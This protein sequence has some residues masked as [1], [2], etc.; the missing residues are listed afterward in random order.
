MR[1]L[2]PACLAALAL[3]CSTA[4]PT[5]AP[6]PRPDL[7]A[8]LATLGEQARGAGDLAG[9]EERFER[10]LAADPGSGA[11]RLGLGRIALARG[12]LER[13][14]R[15]FT[16]AAAAFADS[17]EA[18]ALDAKL[19]LA[20]VARG[21][22]REAE[23][24]ERLERILGADPLRA[25]AHAALA[26]LTGPA[27]SGPADLAEALRRTRAHPYDLAAALAA[28]RALAAVGRSGEA[29][30]RLES[31]LWL[32]DLDP[33]AARSAWAL[34]RELEPS[35]REW[36]LVPVHSWADESI[37]AAPAWRFRLRLAWLHATRGLGALLRVRFVPAGFRSFESRETSVSLNA[38]HDAFTRQVRRMPREGI[39]AVLTAR[40]PAPGQRVARL[41]KAEFLGRR[42]VVRLDDAAAPDRVLLHELLHLYGGVHVA[43]DVKSLMN[44]SETTETLDPLNAAIV[45]ELGRTAPTL[46]LTVRVGTA[47]G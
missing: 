34:L 29:T 45:G 5:R 1:G 19:G 32:A 46:P 42:L 26:A 28:G 35:W 37:R 38:I 22:G 11:A 10:A 16:A 44:P 15:H 14:R 47:G 12:E 40:R 33:A 6:E 36:R 2:L 41:G 39:V 18:S 13:A 25:E 21:Q 31:I 43:R 23:A 30:R 9:A 20:R 4:P 17:D 27:P 8:S 7:A 3:A 24:R